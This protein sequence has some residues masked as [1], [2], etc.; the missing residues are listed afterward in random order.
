MKKDAAAFITRLSS[1]QLPAVPSAVLIP[2]VKFYDFLERKSLSIYASSSTPSVAAVGDAL[3]TED[4]VVGTILAF[5]LAF[6]YSYLNGQSSST[7]FVSW[8]NQIQKNEDSFES[9]ETTI[10]DER[11]FDAKNWKDISREENYVLYNTRVKSSLQK[12]NAKQENSNNVNVDKTE[13]KLVLVALLALFVPI[14]SVEFFFAL[15]RQ[16]LCEVGDPSDRVDFVQKL[17]S[18][19]L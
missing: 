5:I 14:F 19:V 3:S 6:T 18:P 1:R 8:G 17:C 15:S 12:L 7:S 2:R 11:V 4:I 13:N 10:D 16:F 9:T